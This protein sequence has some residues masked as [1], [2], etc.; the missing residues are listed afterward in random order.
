MLFGVVSAGTLI[1]SYSGHVSYEETP[2]TNR[3]RFLWTN[4]ELDEELGHPMEDWLLNQ[5][6]KPRL[7]EDDPITRV[8][9]KTLDKLLVV[10]AAKG[11]KVKLYVFHD[12]GM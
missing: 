4:T 11:I 12:F 3:K 8:V 6:E 2:I 5:R 1:Y 7:S 10:D 9:R